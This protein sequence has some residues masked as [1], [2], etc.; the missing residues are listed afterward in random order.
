MCSFLWVTPYKFSYFEIIAFVKPGFEGSK[1]NDEAHKGFDKVDLESIHCHYSHAQR[2]LSSCP[3]FGS[4]YSKVL[5]LGSRCIQEHLS[6]GCLGK[7]THGCMNKVQPYSD[8]DGPKI[9]K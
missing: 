4:I 8:K 2:H 3:C 6:Q 9:S 7:A 5:R 1:F